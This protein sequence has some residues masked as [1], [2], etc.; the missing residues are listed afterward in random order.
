MNLTVRRTHDMLGVDSTNQQCICDERTMTAPRHCFSAHQDDSLLVRQADQFFEALRKFGRLH[1]IGI[2]SKRG[3]SPTPVGRIAFRVTQPAE[4][5]QVHVSHAGLLQRLGQGRLVEMRIVA[6]TWQGAHIHDA[7]CSVR[8][9]QAH[10]LLERVRGMT[11]RHH[12]G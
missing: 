2:T 10:E 11:N 8:L 12:H 1:V 7:R 6:G 9:K 3:I 5:R 4:C